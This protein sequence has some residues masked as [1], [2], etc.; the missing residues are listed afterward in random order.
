MIIKSEVISMVSV[1]GNTLA[2][3]AA[4]ETG[5]TSE[6]LAR[7]SAPTPKII[8]LQDCID[9]VAALDN[10]QQAGLLP[11]TSLL[12]VVQ[13]ADEVDCSPEET[14]ELYFAVSAHFRVDDLLIEVAHLPRDERWETLARA[15]MRD[16]LYATA[17]LLTT[18]VLNE[19]EPAPAQ[20][21]ID[22]WADQI[23]AAAGRV[24]ES[25][26][27]ILALDSPGLAPLSV[28]LRG[29]RSLLR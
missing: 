9:A 21:R 7:A 22:A 14:A 13:L 1:G 5:D 2:L 3:L 4:D 20:E 16:D 26:E 10:T 27:A 6:Q 18:A 25:L 11:S 29:L 19:T 12:D 24:K 17:E 8:D 23:G 28:A 15:A